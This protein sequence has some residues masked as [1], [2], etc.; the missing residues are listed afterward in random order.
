MTKILDGKALA[1]TLRSKV[2]EEV[3]TLR[4]AGHRAPHLAAILV[5]EDGASMTYVNS[6]EKDCEYVG[7]ESSV[8]RLGADTTEEALLSHIASINN[9]K[10]IDGLIV[11]LPVPKHIDATK[12]TESIHPDIDV[13]G[14]HT[15]NVGKLTIDEDT[16][17][18]ATPFGVIMMLEEYGIETRGKH[19][20]VIG[21]SNIV[22]RPMSILMS[23]GG[24]DATVT[25]C[26]RH[27]H[28]VGAFTRIADI[29]IVAVGIPEFLKP[30]MVKEGATVIDVGITRVDADNKR[31]YLL[32][33]DV[34]Y[35][36]VKEKCSAIT[37]V[38]GGVGPMTRY[39]LLHNTLKS[40][41]NKFNL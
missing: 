30:D 13:D 5:G 28:D 27:T 25:I 7:F 9:N 10:N 15:L 21:R 32:K 1:L 41:K 29:V 40:Y 35:D 26:H 31:G 16:Y 18:S 8:Y 12:I 37:P 39:G 22:G 38:P 11:Q 2:K 34:E 17:I 6:K 23:Q 3:A 4:D 14:F 19:C 36:T 20:V 24:R 33:G